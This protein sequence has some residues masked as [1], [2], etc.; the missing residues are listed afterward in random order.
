MAFSIKICVLDE[1]TKAPEE[2]LFY[3]TIYLHC[4]M[5]LEAVSLVPK[6][7]MTLH[8]YFPAKSVATFL[9]ISL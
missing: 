5:K 3:F 8:V 1:K 7:L 6:S 2:K 9:M 4:T